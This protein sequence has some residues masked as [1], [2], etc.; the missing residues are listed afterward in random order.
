NPIRSHFASMDVWHTG[1]T[2][3][4]GTHGWIGK[5]MDSE[6]KLSG[7]DVIDIGSKASLATEGKTFKPVTFVRAQLF[8]WSVD[9][10]D[11][12]LTHAYDKLHGAPAPDSAEDNSSFILRTACDAQ[13]AS[14]KVR[15]AVGKKSKTNFP[16]GNRLAGQL[17][18]VSAMIRDE[19]PTRIYYV[20]MG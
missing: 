18:K 16:K 19:L 10:I 8:K 1:D 6:A 13:I 4:K 20:A 5:A 15:Q 14:A 11:R 12:N 17:Q 2:T 7:L 9:R 3:G